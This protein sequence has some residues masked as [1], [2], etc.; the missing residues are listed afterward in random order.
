MKKMN[1]VLWSTMSAAALIAGTFSAVPAYAAPAQDTVVAPLKAKTYR[2]SSTQG[3]RCIPVMNGTTMHLGQD[4]AASDGSPIYA[5]ADGTVTLAR[6]GTNA[7]SGY[8]VVRHVLDGQTYYTAYIH[9]W[10]AW[11]YVR[12]GQ[13]VK[14]G[15]RIADVGNSGPSTAPHLHFEVW[16][17]AGWMK[18]PRIEPM[19]WLKKYGIDMKQN[20]SIVYNFKLPSSCQYWAA[21]DLNLRSSASSSAKVIK[22][23]KKGAAMSSVPGAYNNGY[24]QVTVA[25]TKGW[26]VHGAVSPR[27]V[28]AAPERID[29]KPLSTMYYYATANVNLR[30]GPGGSYRALTVVP[31]DTRVK[32]TG[33]AGTWLRVIHGSTTGFVSGSYL[34]RSSPA[35]PAAPA[36]PPVKPA[37]KPPVKPAPKPTPAKPAPKPPVKKPAVAKPA[38]KVVTKQLTANLNLRAGVGTQHKS[39]VVVPRNTKVRVATTSAGWSKISYKGKTGWVSN[40]YLKT[41]AAPAKTVS[42]PAP[43]APAAKAPV[44]KAPA[45][46]AT[47]KSVAKKA[48]A[49]LNMRSGATAKHRSLAVIP[50]N[51]KVT[52]LSTSRGWSKVSYKG[53]TGYASAS[54][55]K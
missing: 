8:I 54:Y 37:P 52:V 14:A 44:K 17:A 4:L 29:V 49:N 45:K 19:Q 20:A 47:V 23:V 11:K 38:P 3:P 41:I 36:K 34:A 32:V 24:V 25:G 35:A 40:R 6:S 43:K 9:M 27:A 51:A 13:S 50:K 28:A 18:G 15:Q 33:S 2:Y 26:A 30:Q 55:L 39:L 48:T 16:G 21:N 10:N 42:K 46:K 31:K 12:P 1:K 5:V 7:S 53:K 22:T